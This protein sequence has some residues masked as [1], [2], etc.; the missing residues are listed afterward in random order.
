M[1]PG[2][3][4]PDHYLDLY[5]SFFGVRREDPITLLE[6]GIA[7][8]AS[9]RYWAEYFPNGMIVGLDWNPP[10]IDHPRI[11][12]VRGNQSDISALDLCGDAFDVIIDDCAHIGSIARLSFERLFP[13]LHHGGIYAI[14]DWGTGYWANWP[15]G[16]AY[17]PGHSAGMVGLV[18]DLVDN[19][20]TENISRGS[21][22]GTATESSQIRS[23]TVVNGLALM[24]KA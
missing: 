14:E 12:T 22:T 20:A 19:V 3:D 24:V 7:T 2:S 13:K 6:L 18:K 17:T 5:D 23:M 15:D 8:G 11:R 9:L 10:L 21:L 1:I 4:K 16:E